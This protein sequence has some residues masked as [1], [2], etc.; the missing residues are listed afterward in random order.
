MAVKQLVMSNQSSYDTNTIPMA[1]IAGAITRQ[2]EDF[3]KAWGEVT[4]ALVDELHSQGFAIVLFDTSDQAGALAYHDMTPKGAPYASVF[5]KT[6][7]DNDGT[8]AKGA[9]SVSAAT[10]HEVVEL[11]GD[12]ACNRYADD[13]AGYEYALETADPTEG[14]SYDI[15]GIAVSN[16]VHPD[17]F[18]PFAKAGKGVKLDHMGLIKKPFEV[19][20]DGYVM[21]HKGAKDA[22][23][24]G[25]EYPGWR[26]AMKTAAHAHTRA[27]ARFA[28][29]RQA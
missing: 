12:P 4:W 2:L 10:S 15:D 20:K 23:V 24:W 26:K 16:F 21:R 6:I 19:R 3:A 17:Y 14:D 7:L 27:N 1:D 9:N 18:N 8:W 13:F 22:T 25:D 28:A 11:L 5:C 29:E